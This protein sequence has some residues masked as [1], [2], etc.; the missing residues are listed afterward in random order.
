MGK[1]KQ[2]VTNV[3]KRPYHCLVTFADG[4]QE[5]ITVEAESLY[6]ATLLFPQDAV[7]WEPIGDNLM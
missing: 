1:T 7:T 6:A 4:H 2:L 3:I 5:E